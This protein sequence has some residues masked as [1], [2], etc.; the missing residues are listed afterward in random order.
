MTR[1][2]FRKKVRGLVVNHALANGY[3][4]SEKIFHF[5]EG[6]CAPGWSYKQHYEVIKKAFEM[7]NM[8]KIYE[9]K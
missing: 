3:T 9:V 1:K 2:T 5:R 7:P 4:P 8:E 6:T